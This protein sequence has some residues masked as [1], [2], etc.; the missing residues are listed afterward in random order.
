[1]WYTYTTRFSSSRYKISGDVTEPA[2]DVQPCGELKLTN[3]LP[4]YV[5]GKTRNSPTAS[6]FPQKLGERGKI[7]G[8]I[9]PL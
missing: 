7:I 6:L 4:S 9:L 8:G 5:N 1:M 3:D 2:V